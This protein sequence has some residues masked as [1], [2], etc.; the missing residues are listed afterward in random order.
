MICVAFHL[1]IVCVY[2][3]WSAVS[4]HVSIW[5]LCFQS[6]LNWIS[7]QVSGI[8]RN[9]KSAVLLVYESSSKLNGI[10]DQSSVIMFRS[11]QMEKEII[12]LRTHLKTAKKRLKVFII[13][14]H[15]MYIH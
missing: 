7:E 4:G 12:A 1:N 15:Y 8:V 10:F 11:S 3:E 6:E 13:Y 14:Y 5:T 9:M 2:S